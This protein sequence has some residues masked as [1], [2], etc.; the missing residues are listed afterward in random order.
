MLDHLNGYFQSIHSHLSVC[1]LA[2][3]TEAAARIFIADTLLLVG[4]LE[5]RSSK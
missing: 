1:R 4:D 5:K 2:W 3:V